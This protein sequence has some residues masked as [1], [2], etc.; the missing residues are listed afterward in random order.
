MTE[1]SF[2]IPALH[3]APTYTSFPDGPRD[4]PHRGTPARDSCGHVGRRAGDFSR[5]RGAGR[6]GHPT[7]PV[8]LRRGPCRRV[9]C[10]T[11]RVRADDGRGTVTPDAFHS[12]AGARAGHR[13]GHHRIALRSGRPYTM[14]AVRLI[15]SRS[16]NRG[17][18][19]GLGLAV[20]NMSSGFR[21]YRRRILLLA[22]IS[23]EHYLPKM[24]TNRMHGDHLPG[25]VSP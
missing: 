4:A 17:F 21:L 16:L 5:G 10:R 11:R 3:E 13:R 7:G 19:R 18:G 23:T 25:A 15:L 9:R 24:W 14:P 12:S 20:R 22:W 6:D 2:G 8:W 1:M